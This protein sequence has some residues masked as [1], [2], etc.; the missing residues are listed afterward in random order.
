MKQ[1]L[2][3]LLLLLSSGYAFG[4]DGDR[5]DYLRYLAQSQGEYDA[6][7]QAQNRQFS[8][9]LQRQWQEF[10][11][12]RGEKHY[13]QQKLPVSALVPPEGSDALHGADRELQP[14][15]ASA[16][17]ERTAQ[18]ETGSLYSKVESIAT[19]LQDSD[20]ATQLPPLT[21][22]QG[23]RVVE[24]PFFGS[25]LTIPYVAEAEAQTLALPLNHH[26]LGGLWQRQSR[27][28][29]LPTLQR[30][31]Q[32]RTLL[33]LNDWGYLLLVNRLS[34]AL[35]PRA[36][37]AR[38]Y[39]WFLL[40]QSGLRTKLG[41]RGDDLYLLTAMASRLYD[42][43][44]YEVDKQRYYNISLLDSKGEAYPQRLRI[45]EGDFALATR[46]FD[47][48]L[49]RLPQLRHDRLLQAD[50]D[51]RYAGERYRIHTRHSQRLL[52]FLATY[53]RVDFDLLFS[54]E[55]GSPTVEEVRQQLS[56][57][58]AGMTEEAAV[59]LLLRFVQTAFNYQRDEEQFGEERYLFADQTL[60]AAGSDCE[61]R[62]V[63]FS[64]LVRHILGLEVVGI[65]YPGHM[66]TAVH[67]SSEVEGRS[68]I[69][70]GKRYVICDP[71]YLYAAV[72]REIPKLQTEERRI[73][74]QPAPV[75]ADIEA[76]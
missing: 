41:Y 9:W 30:L 12:F 63:L 15:L 72:G 44:F 76:M 18:Q 48:G 49:E 1:A 13:L 57:I 29:Y 61:D 43:P 70:Q 22:Q 50:L 39:A 42:L 40:N 17:S 55:M 6:Y 65:H 8:R 5:A 62:A 35:Y 7:L 14:Q 60:I 46:H 56:S 47:L 20:P 21:Q 25:L 51:F 53:P 75:T 3:A 27:L 58:V 11:A 23:W 54:A 38:G 74:P 31:Q 52:D 2:S 33:Q 19:T 36:V 67:F 37:D 69:Y 34:E 28:S 4:V 73:I 26:Q 24:I 59:S 32:I 16:A 45:Y 66:A 64:Y 10:A 68:L 71:T